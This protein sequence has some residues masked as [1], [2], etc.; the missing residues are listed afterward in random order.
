MIYEDPDAAPSR[1]RHRANLD[2]IVDAATQVVFEEGVEALSVKRVADLADYTPGALYRYVPSKDALLA[3]V[4]IRLIE[5]LGAELAGHRGAP[6]GRVVAL[7]HA[8]LA[9]SRAEPHAF[10]LIASMLGDPRVVM[11]DD[12]DAGRVLE[13]V[14]RALAPLTQALEEAARCGALSPGEASERALM[15][16]ASL[17][18]ALMLRKQ[19][20]RAPG[21][22]DSDR[23][24]HAVLRTLLL[25][26]GAPPHA[27]ESALAP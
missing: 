19:E 6:L 27:L 12:A 25:G 16:L 14:V 23:L 18:G 20:R 22:F 4:V 15:L 11:H 7:A 8:Y 5:R 24:F 13:A 26:L 21:L 3:A 2:R 17:Q 10:A 1:R 9:F